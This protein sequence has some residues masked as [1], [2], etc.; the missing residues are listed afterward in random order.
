MRL[1][2]RSNKVLSGRKPLI[3]EAEADVSNESSGFG[4][5]YSV[6]V[7]ADDPI[8]NNLGWEVEV[9]KSRYQK[10]G[11]LMKRMKCTSIKEKREFEGATPFRFDESQ[12][13]SGWRFRYGAQN[14]VEH[15][16]E[17]D[18][19]VMITIQEGDMTY[20]PYYHSLRPGSQPTKSAMPDLSAESTREQPLMFR[21][22]RRQQR[23]S[24]T[25]QN[26]RV[27]INE[28]RNQEELYHPIPETQETW[29]SVVAPACGPGERWRSTYWRCDSNIP[30]LMFD[31]EEE[32]AVLDDV[33]Y[34]VV[35]GLDTATTGYTSVTGHTT[36]VTGD[37]TEA[38]PTDY[39]YSDDSR[40]S[41]VQHKAPIGSDKY[42]KNKDAVSKRTLKPRRLRNEQDDRVFSGVA[43]DLGIVVGFIITDGKDLFNCV[44]ETTK[45][46]VSS[47]RT[48]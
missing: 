37:T 19:K 24:T 47:C 43:E 15:L 27:Q 31:E 29:S 25:R 39:E 20:S 13:V 30:S 38:S 26:P 16:K 6:H 4:T 32:S 45:E 8:A 2:F 7:G 46:T 10:I 11:E 41:V 23:E 17:E 40:G 22:Q 12:I 42:R 3:T 9:Y 36:V 14:D 48:A 44:A 28:N 1:P 21:P 33:S 18:Q 5:D 35:T 34:S